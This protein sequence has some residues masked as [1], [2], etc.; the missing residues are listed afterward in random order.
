MLLFLIIHQKFPIL[1]RVLNQVVLRMRLHQTGSPLPLSRYSVWSETLQ[2][3][4]VHS[5]I[6]LEGS[7]LSWKIAWYGLPPT[8]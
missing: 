7:A 3:A 5:S 1:M 2:M 4:L 8:G 6:L